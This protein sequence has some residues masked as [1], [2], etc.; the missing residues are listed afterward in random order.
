MIRRGISNWAAKR[1]FD[2]QYLTWTLLRSIVTQLSQGTV[3]NW[4]ATTHGCGRPVRLFPGWRVGERSAPSFEAK[5]AIPEKVT[6]LQH[7]CSLET[8]TCSMW[9]PSQS[10]AT[11]QGVRAWAGSCHATAKAVAAPSAKVCPLD[12]WKFLC[13][14]PMCITMQFPSASRRYSKS[15]TPTKF[16]T[17]CFCKRPFQRRCSVLGALSFY[18]KKKERENT[19]WKCL[20]RLANARTGV[21]L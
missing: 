9:Q 19:T 2:H 10:H 11:M 15:I 12:G 16:S 18:S 4:P 20:G 3:G 5:C 14:P 8:C 1:R 21:V 17:L 7:C 13:T 6:E